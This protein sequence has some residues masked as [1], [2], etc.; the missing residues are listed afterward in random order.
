MTKLKNLFTILFLLR[1]LPP[2]DAYR[3]YTAKPNGW[4][5][6]VNMYDDESKFYGDYGRL[7]RSVSGY[8]GRG[9]RAGV[10][11]GNGGNGGA[12]ACGE[13]DNSNELRCPPKTTKCTVPS[14]GSGDEKLTATG[15]AQKAS[16]E[17][18]AA[19]DAQVSAA[20]DASFQA[21]CELAAKAIELAKGVEAV[22][23][24][25]QEL[26]EQARLEISDA[27]KEVATLTASMRCAQENSDLANNAVHD[28]QSLVIHVKNVLHEA[29]KNVASLQCVAKGAMQE[30]T[31]K[32]QI[33]KAAKF[34]AAKLNRQ[35]AEAKADFDKTKM[36]AY[37]AVCAAVEAKQ[38]AQRA[39]RMS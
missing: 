24:G 3:Y 34:R 30:L 32:N 19:Y 39:R 27:E 38:K 18:K 1:V 13:A 22:L 20:E 16:Q 33:L 26:L 17:A 21:K 25:K 14:L 12:S 31:E 6:L 2:L 35:L 10:N 9:P 5:P 29:A 15:Y 7:D 4:E 28:I 36:A 23:A 37:K 11:G 8:G